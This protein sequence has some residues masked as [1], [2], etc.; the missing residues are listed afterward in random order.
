M[1]AERGV[2]VLDQA[3]FE[4]CSSVSFFF[5]TWTSGCGRSDAS[6]G[7]ERKIQIWPPALVF[8]KSPAKKL[9]NALSKSLS[10]ASSRE[11]LHPMFPETP[12]KPLNLAHI[13]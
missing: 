2:S 11:P 3:Q 1:C 12:E 9:S 4:Y 6:T 7:F 8:Q 5:T 13:V 10:C